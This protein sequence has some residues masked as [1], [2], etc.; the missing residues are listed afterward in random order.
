MYDSKSRYYGQEAYEVTDHRGRRVKV[1]AVPEAPEQTEL[2][3]HLRTQGQRL[4]HLA[5]KYLDDGAGFWRICELHDAI[6][7]EALSETREVRI[8]PRT[9]GG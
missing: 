1:V 5:Q 3:V 4:D 9:R 7:P 8:P 2:G 6:L